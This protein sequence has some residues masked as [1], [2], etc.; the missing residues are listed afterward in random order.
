MRAYY[1]KVSFFFVLGM[2]FLAGCATAPARRVDAQA[3]LA[4]QVTAL[5]GQLQDKDRRIQDLETQIDS[6]KGSLSPASSFSGKTA[7]KSKSIGVPGVLVMDVQKAL[8]RKGLDPGPAD[9]RMGRR[10]K[11]AVKEFQRKNNLNA[12]GIV[13]EKTWALLKP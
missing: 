1:S 2:L 4:A 8:E 5:Q 13:G 9:G 7:G 10:T 3:D 11:K 12:D 6:A